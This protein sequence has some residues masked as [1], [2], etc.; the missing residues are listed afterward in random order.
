MKISSHGRWNNQQDRRKGNQRQLE[1]NPARNKNPTR[2]L[3]QLVRI[4]LDQILSNRPEP[5]SVANTRAVRKRV[6]AMK[7][8]TNI[9]FFGDMSMR[10]RARIELPSDRFDVNAVTTKAWKTKL[11]E[12]L[13]TFRSDRMFGLLLRLCYTQLIQRPVMVHIGL[14]CG[15]KR[16]HR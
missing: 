15:N 16:V 12:G 8:M 2:P 7:N 10:V 4:I 11:S 3:Q 13:L 5:S 1:R 14:H 6:N 9:T